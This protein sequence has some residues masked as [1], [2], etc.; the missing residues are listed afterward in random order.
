[1]P[2]FIESA[3]H[4]PLLLLALPAALSCLYLL[5]LTLLSQKPKTPQPSSKKLRFDVI[6]PAHNEAVVIER[7]IASLKKI[8]WP[9]NGY[10]LL[11]VADNCT[12]TTAT[13]AR[14]AGAEVLERN[15][16][17]NRGKG[18]ALRHA[19]EASRKLGWAD[20]VVI[21]DADAEVSGNLLEACASRIEAGAKAVQVH[22]GVLNPLSAWRTRL[23]AIA[24]GA[25]H[26]ARSRG[27]ERLGLSCGLRGNGWCVTHA[28]LREVP[29]KAFSLTEDIEYGIT[30][31][32]AGHRVW[33]ADEAHANAE[34]VS[35]EATARSQRARWEG[36][37]FEMIRSMSLPLLRAAIL[38]RS[39]LCLDLAFDLLVLP[40]S[41]VV[42]NVAA[43]AVFA[44]LATAASPDFIPWLQLSAACALILLAY[45]LRGWQLSGTGRQGLLDLAQAPLYLVWK[46]VLVS[47]RRSPREWIRTERE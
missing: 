24:K 10:R 42:L 37:R 31:G 27:R 33:Y 1:M 39:K 14:V 11:V 21:I 30:L 15:D 17:L 32:L 18:Y 29:Y 38:R 45:V 22:Y 44:A 46:H 40:L 41:Y 36:G 23:I 16:E 28:L 19:F 47:R 9:E 20:A 2:D 25:F 43:L 5:A 7:T 8:D 6:V 34:M 26:I 12:D 13:L 4:L 35:E 3:L